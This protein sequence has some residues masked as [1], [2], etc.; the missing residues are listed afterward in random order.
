[1]LPNKEIDFCLLI[2]CY[3][4]L[5]G[6]IHSLKTVHYPTNDFMIVVVDDGSKEAIG[7][8]VLQNAVGV[9][10]P[11][12]VLAMDK[13]QG[14]TRALN[15]GLMWIRANV[16]TRYIARLDCADTCEAERFVVQVNY[17]DQHPETG[18]VGSWCYFEDRIK[19]KRYTYKAPERHEEIIRE[20]HFRNVF[21]HPT[22]MFRSDVLETIGLYPMDFDYAED[23]AFCWKLLQIRQSFVFQ[24]VLVTCEVNKKGISFANKGKQLKARWKTVNHF[25][26]SKRLKIISFMRLV[27]LFLLPKDLLLLLKNARG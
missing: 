24:Y 25:G 8:P 17:L 4:N 10:I 16:N 27:L 7:L 9:D 19:G 22:I 1:M 11:I 23:Y 2:P 6:L 26:S 15:Y 5:Q 18:L 13:N 3:N 21:I 20:M 14:I 12:T